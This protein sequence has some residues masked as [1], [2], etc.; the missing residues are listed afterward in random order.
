[1]LYFKYQSI[2]F[3]FGFAKSKYLH[4]VSIWKRHRDTAVWKQKFCKSSN[5]VFRIIVQ[6]P[7]WIIVFEL[8]WESSQRYILEHRKWWKVFVP[9]VDNVHKPVE[10]SYVNLFWYN[11]INTH[12]RV[13]LGLMVTWWVVEEL[14][15]SVSCW[16]SDRMLEV[17]HSV[18]VHRFMIHC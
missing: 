4:L 5:D 7:R 9:I 3:F 16:C 11:D 10:K 18:N 14:E 13:P 17:K 6:R 15:P 12:Q 2:S 1:M 8:P